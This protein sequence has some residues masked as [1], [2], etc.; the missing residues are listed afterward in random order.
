MK[1]IKTVISRLEGAREIDGHYFAFC[2]V[3]DDRKASL[4]ITEGV[5]GRVL[6]YCHAGCEPETILAKI[7]LSW[8]DLY[9]SDKSEYRSTSK[10]VAEYNYTDAAGNLLYQ[11]VRFDPKDFRQRQPD[12]K[13]GW[14]WTLKDVQTVLYRLPDII[15]AIKATRT[16]FVV[17]GEKDADNLVRLGFVAT[18]N[19]MGA[20][21]WK[22]EYSHMLRGAR[23]VILPDN[24]EPGRKHALDVARSLHAHWCIVRIVDLPG[25]GPKE[26]VS[27]WI[28]KGGT[29]DELKRL[30]L[31]SPF[32]EPPP[33]TPGEHPSLDGSQ[34]KDR[35]GQIGILVSDVERERL[36]W[37]WPGRLAL[38]KL[39]ILDGDPGL[40]KSTLY[41]DLAAR[42]T[43]GRSWPGEEEHT[44]G[45]EHSGSVVIVTCEDAIGDTI[46]PRLEEAGA[47][48][49]RCLVVQTVPEWDDKREQWTERV[50]V[51]PD[52]LPQIEE[53]VKR[54]DARLLI[55]DPL[56]A[57][58]S[59]E[60][61]SFRDQDVRR[62]LAP[63]ANLV[64]RLDVAAL[65][66]RHLNK[67]SGGNVL[68]RGGGSIGIV[69]AARL[70]ML[71][72]RNPND[73]NALVLASTK[74]NIALQPDSLT[75]RIVS[76]SNDSDVGIVQWEGTTPLTAQELVS[77][78]AGKTATKQDEATEWLIARLSHGPVLSETL[79]R[80]AKDQGLSRRTL[81]RAK[82]D[83]GI[84]AEAIGSPAHG[85][86]WQWI[87]P[88][89][90]KSAIPIDMALLNEDEGTDELEIASNGR[91]NANSLRVPTLFNGSNASGTLNGFGTLKK[92]AGTLKTI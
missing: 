39:S 6:I 74:A 46:R 3:H 14:K 61:N 13:G 57:H 12:G 34:P 66:I 88:E 40:G 67:A 90:L 79:I 87:L 29:A 1:P 43:T 8:K 25:L 84:K 17:E 51:I 42:L 70:G 55:I 62:A 59:G 22:D 49:S 33:D 2:P 31:A 35:P 85:G 91:K 60:I 72:A 52:D 56:F 44:Y 81:F 20:G 48:L 54:V 73:E 76:S 58:L 38:G 7:G 4:S 63:L 15:Q 30:V 71:L 78:Y 9:P 75:L 23:V 92:D 10:I 89:E 32:Y 80:E 36:R 26:D 5:D 24:D 27:D 83:L 68:Y 16:I 45:P 64:E 21:K 37:L 28:K 53:A 18:C 47:D 50:P 41:C 19:P 77:S 65:I 86:S 11:A 82:K 69:G